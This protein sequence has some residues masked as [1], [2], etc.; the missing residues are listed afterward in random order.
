L[1]LMV[2]MLIG[3]IK[4]LQ[5][6]EVRLDMPDPVITGVVM[7]ATLVITDAASR[8]RRIELPTVNNLEWETRRGNT[9][10]MTIINGKRTQSE[11]HNV[12]FRVTGDMPV[13]IPA[14]TVYFADDSSVSTTERTVRPEQPNTN[15]S[16][17]AYAEANFEPSTIVP[18]EPSTLTYRL[19]LRQDRKRAIKEPTFAPP[20]ELLSLGER[21]DSTSSTID[22]EGTEWQVQ[23]WRWPVSA[24]QAGTFTAVGQ[25]KW[26]RCR[27]DL[28]RQLIA[29]SE[30]NV[31]IKPGKLTVLALPDEGRPEDFSGLI[32][33]LVANASIDRT[34]IATGEGTTFT[35]TL[36]GMQIGLARRP[37]INL[38]NTAQ[39]YPKDDTTAKDLRTF[40]WDI[41]PSTTG[42][43]TIPAISF[44]YFDP[45]KK[46]YHRATTKPLTIEIIPG[47][48]R[49]LVVSGAI[50]VEKAKP[51]AEIIALP[52]PMRGKNA[53]QPAAGLWWM[54]LLVALA[55]GATAGLGQR[56]LARPRR[57]PHRG[58]ALHQAIK[59]GDLDAIAAALF[60]LRPD[61]NAEQ[62]SIADA[63]EQRIDQAR[64]GG[65]QSVEV[66]QLATPLLDI[67]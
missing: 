29:E 16:G 30:H 50:E 58:R 39:A 65:G 34:R 11:T 15:L 2:L 63:I 32:G 5:A 9:T 42:E 61:L 12:V 64:F 55:A 38:P 3:G 13:T 22:A 24:A 4:P 59:S 67:H 37:V 14:V 17:E 10:Q 23:T 45:Q 41:V 44:P 46:A 7:N 53:T 56:W 35:V 28:F 66:L 54:V 25:Q 47:R 48:Q 49:A 60:A 26:F 33:P 19:Y 1:L 8:V 31:A 20:T 43:L 18:G 21:S 52:P 62:K 36:T 51:A 27:E 40:T 57:G 6:V